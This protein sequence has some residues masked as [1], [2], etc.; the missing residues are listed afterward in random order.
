MTKKTK[1]QLNEFALVGG[2]ADMGTVNQ[3]VSRYPKLSDLAEDFYK[4]EDKP[5]F[6]VREFVE[7]VGRYNEIGKLIYREND[8]REVAQKLSRIAEIAK[9]HA[10]S[11]VDEDFDKITIN[12]NMKSLG[13]ASKEFNK[14]AGD[15]AQVQQRLESLYEDMGHILGRYYTIGE[16][17]DEG[18]ETVDENDGAYEKFFRSALKKFG[19]ESPDELED[20]KKKEFYNYVDDNYKAKSEGFYHVQ[21]AMKS[22]KKKKK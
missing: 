6:N 13:N 7:E 4:N 11:Q 16:V 9:D 17:C 2:Y 5:K 22:R 14:I 15:A 8:I 10:L 19:V 18:D 1:K 3:R 20:D 12:K 21:Q